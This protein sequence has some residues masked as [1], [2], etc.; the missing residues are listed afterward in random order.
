MTHRSLFST[1]HIFFAEDSILTQNFTDFYCVFL[2]HLD[3]L[4]FIFGWLQSSTRLTW[5]VVSAKFQTNYYI[6]TFKNAYQCDCRGAIR[7]LVEI[8][9][10]ADHNLKFIFSRFAIWNFSR[11][12]NNAGQFNKRCVRLN[13]NNLLL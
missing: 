7:A 9:L 1:P 5:K 12:L 3:S 13:W 8:I 11:L 6:L 2:L 10:F 4:V